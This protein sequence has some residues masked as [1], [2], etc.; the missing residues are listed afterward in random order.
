MP[1]KEVPFI[2]NAPDNL[3]CYQACIGMVLWHF[4]GTKKAWKELEKLTGMKKGKWTWSTESI[5][6]LHTMGFEIR[7]ESPFDAEEFVK[8][9][10][11]YLIEAMGKDVGEA[12]ARHSD[13]PAERRRAKKSLA[14]GTYTKRLPNLRDINR[15]LKQG[16]LIICNVNGRMFHGL[17]GYTGHFV[18]I[19]GRDTNHLWIHDPGLPPREAMRVP[20]KAFKRVWEYPDRFARNVLAIKKA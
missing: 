17:D 1:K 18:L 3:H 4:T 10:K 11:S 8:R 12:Q 6:R 7:E 5:L 9:G 19:Y 16:Y 2:G 14:L 15:F 13:L 20:L